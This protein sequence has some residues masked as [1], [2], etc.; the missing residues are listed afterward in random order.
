MMMRQNYE[1]DSQELHRLLESALITTSTRRALEERLAMAKRENRFFSDEQFQLLSAVCDCLVDQPS[2]D[3]MVNVAIYIAD[4]LLN[5]KKDGW[6]FNSMPPDEDM[7][8][9]G[10]E[11]I[12][13]TSVLVFKGAFM[14]LGRKEQMQ[15]LQT[16]QDGKP[17]GEVWK[18]M[19]ASTFFEELLAEVAET[20]Y[21]YPLIQIEIGYM[22]MAD[23]Y[24]WQKIGLDGSD[25]SS[26][27]NKSST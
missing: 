25:T 27:T 17:P 8:T 18:Q 3:R 12:Q 4:R 19:P 13:Q 2:E 23:A 21:S 6:R 20:F 9:M 10:L 16:I 5:K 7:Y 24:G 14:N 15:V 11:G 22:G 1:K 26:L